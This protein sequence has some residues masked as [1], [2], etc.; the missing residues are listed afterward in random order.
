MQKYKKVSEYQKKYVPLHTIKEK[1]DRK[2]LHHK[3]NNIGRV[4]FLPNQEI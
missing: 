1:N 4:P 3:Y 2:P